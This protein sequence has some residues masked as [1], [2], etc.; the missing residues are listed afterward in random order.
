MAGVRY[1]YLVVEKLRRSSRYA[2]YK[3]VF[4][5]VGVVQ[6]QWRCVI[7]APV[8]VS[9][10][11]E[12]PYDQRATKHSRRPGFSSRSLCS[13]TASIMASR[14]TCISVLAQSKGFSSRASSASSSLRKFS[15]KSSNGTATS[16]RGINEAKRRTSS[17][18]I[19][20]KTAFVPILHT[21]RQF[22]STPTPRHGHLDTP[23][24]GEE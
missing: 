13:H 10:T 24:P 19:L 20:R 3:A 23:K 5:R 17:C 18:L 12:L 16:Q 1:N 4:R 11:S 8:D 7:R 22:S 21:T 14:R 2:V 6:R 15:S 9:Q